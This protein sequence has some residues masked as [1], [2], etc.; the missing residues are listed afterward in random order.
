MKGENIMDLH[1]MK[2]VDLLS[3]S[4]ILDGITTEPLGMLKDYIFIILGDGPRTGKSWLCRSLRKHGYLAYEISEDVAGLIIY[5][6]KNN[7]YLVDDMH[8]QVTIILNRPI[9]Q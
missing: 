3:P 7:H 1:L 6:D 4:R 5:R 8:K 2:S 9:S